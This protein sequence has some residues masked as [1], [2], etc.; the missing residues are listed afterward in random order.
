[1]QVL[2]LR[3]KQHC[4]LSGV[5]LDITIHAPD[6]NGRHLLAFDRVDN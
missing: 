1:M 2:D 3:W 5:L 4:V 6:P